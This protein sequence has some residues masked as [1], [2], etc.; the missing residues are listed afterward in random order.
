ML[1]HPVLCFTGDIL[2]K[3]YILVELLWE[4]EREAVQRRGNQLKK[5][6][7]IIHKSIH[8]SAL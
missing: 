4:V 5:V 1:L 8:Y 6:I 3:V 2:S 7:F